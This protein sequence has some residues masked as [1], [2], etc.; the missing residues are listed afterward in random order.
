MIWFLS[1]S[2]VVLAYFVAKAS[3]SSRGTLKFGKLEKNIVWG[4][5]PLLLALFVYGSLV[6]VKANYCGSEGRHISELEYMH[7]AVKYETYHGHMSV[8][9][10]GDEVSDFL[11]QHP[12]CC[13]VLMKHEMPVLEKWLSDYPVSVRLEY[14]S[15]PIRFYGEKS[16][17]IWYYESYIDMDSC[18][19]VGKS[20][21]GSINKLSE[22]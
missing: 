19:N 11:K 13:R 7:T 6:K 1:I 16:D 18:G 2:L 5:V 12:N 9:A 21:R 17:V 3:V 15:R 20:Y 14:E 8:K 10:R 22:N 4:G